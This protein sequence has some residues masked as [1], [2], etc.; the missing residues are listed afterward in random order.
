MPHRM[1]SGSEN[2]QPGIVLNCVVTASP[3]SPLWMALRRKARRRKRALL[4][5]YGSEYPR[6]AQS[7]SP[8]CLRQRKRVN[9]SSRKRILVPDT[10]AEFL[11]ALE[12]VLEEEG[13]NT[14]TTW[15]S[16]EAIALLASTRF[17]ALLVGEHPPEVKSTELFKRLQAKHQGI[18][19]IVMQSA[20]RHPFEAQHLC[21]L[22]AYA[23]IPEWEHQA[24]VEQL[25]QSL[26]HS[27]DTM[28][29]VVDSGPKA[30]AA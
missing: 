14:T 10:D 26:R 16:R 4:P 7:P 17:D 13:F 21:A 29:T 5:R 20:P 18:P 25:R 1:N 28:M 6:G 19:C 15:D 9:V 30:T 24:I 2:L 23:V 27:H 11:I 22:G 12:H 3:T 8:L